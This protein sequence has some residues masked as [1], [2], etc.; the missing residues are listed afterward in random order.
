[1][2]QRFLVSLTRTQQYVIQLVPKLLGKTEAN[3]LRGFLIR[4][5]AGTFGLKI[6]NAFFIYFSSW[7]LARLL[8]AD[9]YG[10]YAYGIAWA[11]LLMIPAV[12]GLEGLVTR[13]VAV[14]QAQ[15]KWD[16]THGILRWSNQVVV[17]TSIG[18]ALV[19]SGVAWFL[20][21]GAKTDNIV[22]FWIAMMSLPFLSISRL[23]ES[24]MRA[25]NHILV[26]Q[27]PEMVI[28]PVLLVLFI[29]GAF[30]FF[31]ESFTAPWGMGINTVAVAVACFA[32]IEMLRRAL[33]EKVVQAPPKYLPKVWFVSA[34]PMLLIGS[35]YI[36]NNQTDT[37]MLG[38]LKDTEAVGIYTVANRG[39]S[40]I[41]FVLMAFNTSFAPTFASLYA[42]GDRQQLQEVVKKC[43]RMTF[44]AA[45][46]IAIPLMVLSQW[47]LGIFGEEFISG[48]MVLIILSLG[49]LVCAFTGSVA[50]LL[51]MTGYERDTAIGVSCSALLNM[52]LNYLLIP[53]WGVE[54]AAIATASSTLFWN[55]LLVVFA[56]KR[57][58]INSTVFAR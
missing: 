10:S 1:M 11:S 17:L 57:L 20:S 33:P 58:R 29:S 13:E 21:S 26:G 15:E 39:A 32:G 50:L 22:V 41:G 34:L 8:G 48:Q 37:V 19:A 47:L 55:I 7:L 51:I 28:R 16:L 54:G 23:R 14:Y 42:Q 27:L 53:K 36:V 4:A 9:G 2:Y 12:L 35:M 49:N 40:L 44:L 38:I 24:A 43:C 52:I 56:Y 6:V 45:L 30:F 46:P 31:G 18:L 25:L 5:T 3:S